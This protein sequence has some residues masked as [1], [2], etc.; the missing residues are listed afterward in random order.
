M[1]CGTGGNMNEA[2]LKD[3]LPEEPSYDELVKKRHDEEFAKLTPELKELA[4]VVEDLEEYHK[5]G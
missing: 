1:P 3:K 4:E 5:D 2:D